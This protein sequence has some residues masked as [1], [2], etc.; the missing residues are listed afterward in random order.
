MLG[1]AKL[2]VCLASLIV[3]ELSMWKLMNRSVLEEKCHIRCWDFILPSKSEWDFYTVSVS[4]TASKKIEA[5]IRSV[6]FLFLVFIFFYKST[7]QLC[8]E[9]LCH[10]WVYTSSRYIDVLDKLQKPICRAI[11]PSLMPTLKPW[12][13]I[14]M[15]PT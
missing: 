14:E 4:K 6:K 15:Q 2:L 12:L 7:I 11:V 3:L 9:C 8:M 1:K 10:V 13:F 5:L